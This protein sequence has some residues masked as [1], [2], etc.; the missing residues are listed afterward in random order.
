[1][2]SAHIKPLKLRHQIRRSI[3][4]IER[5]VRRRIKVDPI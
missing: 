5:W 4:S 2:S 3:P 1:M